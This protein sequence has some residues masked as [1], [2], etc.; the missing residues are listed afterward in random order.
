MRGLKDKRIVVCGGAT[1]IGAATAERLAEEGS[2]VLIG[3]VNLAGARETAERIAAAGGTAVAAAFDLADE[4]SVRALFERAVAE[5]G[6]VD[7]LFNVGADL[8]QATLGRDGDGGRRDLE[9][10]PAL[11]GFPL[12]SEPRVSLPPN[13]AGAG[14]RSVSQ[15]DFDL[16]CV[17]VGS[18]W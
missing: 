18:S 17:T 14:F 2:R 3:D 10:N 16:R 4:A 9:R 8:S 7:G 6:G 15:R 11:T 12:V 1:G 13:A 5:L